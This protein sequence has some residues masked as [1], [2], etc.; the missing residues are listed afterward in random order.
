MPTSAMILGGYTFAKMPQDMTFIQK[1][2]AFAYQQTYTSV[3]TFSWGA[4][5]VGK[6]IEISWPMMSTSQYDSLLTL[7]TNN[8]NIVFNPNDGNSKTFNVEVVS[9]NGEY[10]IYLD[11]T[12]G[13]FSKNVKLQLLITSEA[14]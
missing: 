8:A 12:T 13:H 2:R 14:S 7:Y 3:A 10:Q 6:L 5:Y 11:N 9:L 1:Q 4:S